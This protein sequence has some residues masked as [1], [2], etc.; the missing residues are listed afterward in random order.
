MDLLAD[1]VLAVRLGAVAR[2]LQAQLDGFKTRQLHVNDSATARHLYATDG[3]ALVGPDAMD[4]EAWFKHKGKWASGQE[5]GE[6]DPPSK[7]GG[8]RT[9]AIVVAAAGV[10]TAVAMRYI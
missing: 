6:P 9:A 2:P 8:M 1:N 3:R 5:F 4:A 10:A 7:G